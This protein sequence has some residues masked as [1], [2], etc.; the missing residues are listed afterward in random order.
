MGKAA[1]RFFPPATLLNWQIQHVG[2]FH[3]LNENKK[4]G[5]KMKKNDEEQREI[6]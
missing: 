5:K 2:L 3:R 4:G 6:N 1:G